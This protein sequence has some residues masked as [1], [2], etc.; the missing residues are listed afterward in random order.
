MSYCSVGLLHTATLSNDGTVFS[1]GC[2]NHGQ[3]GLHS[4]TR[5]VLL[6]TQIPNLPKISM[7]SCGE[8]FTVCVDY[9]GSMWSFGQNNYGQL[10]TGNTTKCNYP[11]MIGEIPPV[12]SVSCGGSH[13]LIVTNDFNLWSCGL[14]KDGQLCI[15]NPITYQPVK[16]QPKPQQPG[17]S[18][19][20][21]ISA[22]YCH[23][24]FQNEK[25]EIYK[26]GN[27]SKLL[28][29]GNNI[30]KIPE[31]IPNQPP[32]IIQF[33]SGSYHVLFLDVEGEVFSFGENSF[34]E[35]GI[36]NNTNQNKITQISSIPPIKSIYSI[37]S[38]SYLIDYFG[39][40]WS[41]GLNDQ[42]QLGHGDKTNY[43]IPSKI[44]SIKSI[45]LIS[46]GACASHFIA[47]NSHNKIF[48]VGNNTYGQLGTGNKEIN[49]NPI[50]LHSD[51][52][53]I[54]GHSNSINNLN[55]WEYTSSK[56]NWNKGELDKL[57]MLQSKIM[58]VKTN[59]VRN[60]D[61]T[62]K[63][64][65]PTC[66][67]ESW[68]DVQTFLNEKA[69]QCG[70]NLKEKKEHQ[71]KIHETI[72][73]IE[74]ECK[75]VE[76]KILQ[77]QAN[78]QKLEKK[79]SECK[80]EMKTLGEDIQVFE[81]NH[82]IMETMCKNTSIFCENENKMNNEIRNLFKEKKFENFDCD[83]ISKLLWKM[84]LVQYQ[85]VFEENQIN[86]EFASMMMDDWTV[87]KQIG[88]DKRDCF[89]VLFYFKMMKSPYYSKT[90]SSDYE[91]DCFVCSHNTPEKTIHL[92]DEYDISIDKELIL[93]N[94]FCAPIFTFPTVVKDL[95]GIDFLSSTGRETM[96]ELNKWAKAHEQHLKSLNK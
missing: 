85:Q 41:F 82:E 3:L 36:G 39:V 21:K 26:C 15:K 25:G 74:N 2:N 28:E 77:L 43:N 8:H 12:L 94:N 76:N 13:T 70:S 55:D 86:G 68:S 9:K 91:D 62:K 87:W 60:N 23:S 56:L 22:G 5:K 4:N 6:P 78:K 95:L 27:F 11:Q 67:F 44:S 80:Q 24:I 30:D 45:T 37:G 50:E 32:N 46:Q 64:E 59:L 81:R 29:L 96:V 71:I 31:L 75:D 1:F 10:G 89:Y 52:C 83:D 35:L 90:L 16:Y 48:V 65:F 93:E 40:V 38:S 58:Q 57:Q 34:G 69:Q 47:K 42:N 14:N 19:I 7:I 73:N 61:C 53:N 17:Y 20:L 33:C 49:V 88:L 18:N 51:Y 79:L 92:L 63:Q 72:Q 54:L 84:D 66:S